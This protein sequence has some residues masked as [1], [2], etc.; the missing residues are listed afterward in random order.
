MNIATENNTETLE[1]KEVTSA[2]SIKLS[3]ESLSQ[4]LSLVSKAVA[5]SGIQPILSNVLLKATSNCLTLAATD[6]DLSLAI[7]I[8]AEVSQEGEVT[9]PAQKLLELISKLPHQE[10]T[11]KSSDKALINVSCGRSKF[12]IKGLSSEQFPQQFFNKANQSNDSIKLPLKAI[13]QAAQ[14][15]SFASDKR[16]VNS[17]LNGICLEL[18]EKGLELAATD[19][20]RLAYYS[21]SSVGKLEETK[22]VIIPFRTITELSRIIGGLDDEYIDC[23]L[24]SPSQISFQSAGRVLSSSLI[25]GN[26]PKYQQLI[27]S[28]HSQKAVL[29]NSLFLSALERVSVLANERT[30]VIKLL[31]EEIGVLTVSANTPDLGEAQDQLDLVEFTGQDFVIAFNVNYMIECLR[32]L[33][34]ES[35]ELKMT[36]PLKPIIVCPFRNESDVNNEAKESQ[37]EPFQYIYLLMPVQIRGN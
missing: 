7:D 12:E 13:R 22:K 15:V 36:E 1:T 2:L 16:E 29:N 10:L 3:Q 33:D 37:A 5:K 9:I 32:N 28:S 17:I 19:G 20:S 21:D 24:A 23:N 6:L 18:S 26:Y 8:P 27:P 25:D 11:L 30:K 14:L 34:C 35:I 31:F 4:A